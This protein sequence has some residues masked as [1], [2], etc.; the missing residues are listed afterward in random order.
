MPSAG[1]VVSAGDFFVSLEKDIN[2]NGHNEHN[3]KCLKKRRYGLPLEI[4]LGNNF[5]DCF[6]VVPVAFVVVK[7]WLFV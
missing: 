7:K 4:P 2:H 6:Y 5:I 3:E 1:R